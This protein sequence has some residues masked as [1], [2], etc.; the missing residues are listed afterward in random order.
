[1]QYMKITFM[2]EWKIL[3]LNTTIVKQAFGAQSCYLFQKRLFSGVQRHSISMK[4][5]FISELKNY[6]VAEVILLE[7]IF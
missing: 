1:M 3:F 2:K 4:Q 7:K 5:V 6:S